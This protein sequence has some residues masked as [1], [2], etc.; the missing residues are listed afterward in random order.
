MSGFT[1][2]LREP[3]RQRLDLSPLLPERLAGMTPQAVGAIELA[4]G[5]RRLRLSQVFDVAGEAGDNLTIRAHGA[6]LDGLGQ[7][8]TRGRIT[9]DGDAGAY[10]GFAMSGGRI[11]IRGHAGPFAGAAMRGGLLEIDGNAGDWLGGGLPGERRGMAGGLI[12]LRGNAGDRAA[13]R[14]RRG[15]ILIEGSAGDYLGAR[16]VA[17]TTI[18]MGKQVGS[19]PGFA[20]KRGSLLLLG[21]VRRML[22]TFAD[23]GAHELGFLALLAAHL[24]AQLPGFGLPAPALPVKVRRL[25][26]DAAAGG[27]GEIL[28]PAA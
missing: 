8:M 7:A 24:R 25:V 10:A 9:L 1:L 22:P 18:V 21:R 3:P 11:A 12:H 6:R 19:F 16:M 26:G 2:S 5:N 20:M 27:R 14:Q 23:S 13:D 28:M 4:C 15:I 17:G